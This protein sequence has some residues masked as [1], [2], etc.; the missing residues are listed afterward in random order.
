MGTCASPLSPVFFIF[1][2]FLENFDQ[3]IGRI[4]LLSVALDPQLDTVL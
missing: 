4:P 1:M 2:Q 3:I